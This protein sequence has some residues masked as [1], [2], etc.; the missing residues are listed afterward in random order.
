MSPSTKKLARLLTVTRVPM[1]DWRKAFRL[2]FAQL[3]QEV[4][5]HPVASTPSSTF[6][7]AART[8]RTVAAEC[9][10]LGMGLVMHLYPLCA[11]R[12]VPLPWWTPANHRRQRLLRH[13]DR[14]ALILSN[15]GSERASGAHAPVSLSRTR[16]GLRVDGKYDY[17]S[18]ANTADLVLFSAPLV[19]SDASLFCIADLRSESARIGPPRFTGSMQ[20]SD[21]CSVTFDDQLL[22]PGRFVP[23]PSES[24]LGCMTQYQR[25]WFQLL[26]GEAHLARLEHLRRTWNLPR[27]DAEIPGQNELGLLRDYALHLLDHAGQPGAVSELA[28]VSAALKLRISGM[29]QS[30]AAAIQGCDPT[31]AEELLF[32]KR[33]PTSDDRILRSI[34]VARPDA[35]SRVNA[36]P[37]A[38]RNRPALLL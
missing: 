8:A 38:I 15:A 20:L 22:P 11:L 27:L 37:P 3:R 33:Q 25:G 36:S 30:L 18:L 28:R 5:L 21:T 17:V 16:D 19:G 6:E 13:I 29:A 12:C 31:A 2:L 1:E 9:L 34:G 14:H 4:D 10:P 35:A 23:V 7:A 24:A 32:Y 26:S